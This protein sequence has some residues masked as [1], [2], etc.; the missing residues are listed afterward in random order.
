MH[1]EL[2]SALA[3]CGLIERDNRHRDIMN[4]YFTDEACS[5]IRTKPEY[6][7]ASFALSMLLMPDSTLSAALE[8]CPNYSLKPKWHTELIFDFWLVCESI[9]KCYGIL[10]ET[11]IRNS[12]DLLLKMICRIYCLDSENPN[13]H[14]IF[15]ND[16]DA[17]LN[18]VEK[19]DLEKDLHAGKF[20]AR[21]LSTPEIP[22]DE[23]VIS[24]DKAISAD[25]TSCRK[26]ISDFLYKHS[27]IMAKFLYKS[28]KKPLY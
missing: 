26:S 23:F 22:S 21:I 13:N 1:D 24:L 17:I 4:T 14:S 18:L 16:L 28:T 12:L 8:H 2:V 25:R 6:A 7:I 27:T 5:Y 19:C 20:W 15:V 9:N 10:S 11:M 3:P